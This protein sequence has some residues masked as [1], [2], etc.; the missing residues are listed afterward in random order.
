MKFLQTIQV[1]RQND[2]SILA[3]AKAKWVR[4]WYLNFQKKINSL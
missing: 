1:I 2:F 4:N 3:I